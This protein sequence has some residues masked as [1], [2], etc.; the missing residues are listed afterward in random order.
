MRLTKLLL[1]GALALVSSHAAA[2]IVDGVRQKPTY[3]TMGFVTDTEV[4]LYNVG[5][6]QFFTQGNSWGTQA[7]VGEEGRLIKF[8]TNSASDYTM[9]CYCW[10]DENQQGGYMAADWRY[11]FYDSETQMFV[12]RN[13]QAN[14]FYTVVQNVDGTIRIS[15]SSND[16]DY[17]LYSGTMFMGVPKTKNEGVKITPFL[18]PTEGYVDWAIVSKESYESLGEQLAIYIKAQELKG[19]IDKIK[20]INGNYGSLESVYLDESSS[21]SQIEAAIANAKPLYDQARHDYAVSL[22]NNASDK[23]NVDITIALANP[24]F[25]ESKELE[26]TTT[27]WTTEYTLGTHGT[28]NNLRTGGTSTNLCYESWQMGT[29][30]IYQEVANMPAGVYEIEVQGFY[31]YQNGSNGWNAYQAQQ[32]EYVKDS[33]VP[34]YV[35]LNSNQ[36]PFSNIYKE[37]VPVNTLYQ[38]SSYGSPYTDPNNQYWYPNEMYNSAIAFQAGMYKRSAYGLVANDGETLRLGVKGS[39]DQSNASW[40]IWDNFKL[41]Y[42]GFQPDVVQP[43]LE[44]AMAD[45]NQYANLLMGKTE[46]ANLSNALSAAQT[47]IDNQDGEAMFQALNALYNVKESVIAS[48]DLFLAQ[49]VDTDLNNLRQAIT[50]YAEQKLS[51]A[52]RTAATT[53]ED[54][55]AGNK[56]Y[57]GSEISQLKEDVSNAINA[58]SNSAYQYSQL[59]TAITALEAAAQ[60]KAN[61]ALLNEA[62]ELITSAQEGYN[63][64]SFADSE[65]SAQVEAINA[66]VSAINTSASLY[67][68]LN[69]A[70]NNLQTSYD[71]ASAATAHVSQTT[72]LKAQLRLND[73]KTKY[74]N[75]TIADSNIETLIAT[76][77]SLGE[78]L[79][80]SKQLYE[81]F[82]TSIAALK[83]E[84]DK[85]AKVAAAVRTAAEGTYNAAVTAYNEGAIDDENIESENIKLNAAVASLSTSATRYQEL[86]AAIP[87]LQAA[88]E[89]KAMKSLI[90]DAQTLLTE[91][92]TGYNDAT[93]ADADIADIMANMTTIETSID[94]SAAQYELLVP[95]IAK[96]Q[97]AILEVSGE[98]AHV[99][100]TTR[101]KANLRLTQTQNQYN[102]GTI[103]DEQIPSR[104]T[105]IDDLCDELTHSVHL[106]NQFNENIAAL[107]TELDKNEKASAETR[108]AAETAYN[109]ALTAYNE[110]SIDDDNIEAEGLKL[111]AAIT[112][113]QNSVALYSQF[114]TAI[115]GLN[116]E[117]EKNNKVAATVR[118][119]ADDDYAA[120]VAAYGAGT[121]A[122][123]NVAAE[124]NKLNGDV[125]SLQSS[126]AAYAQLATAIA[127]LNTEL[128]KNAKVYAPV[129][130]AAETD[131]ATAND[132]YDQA[133]IADADIP[134]EVATLNA[135]VT[136]LQSSATAYEGLNTAITGFADAVAAADGKVADG[137]LTSANTLLSAT[138]TAYDEGS[139]ED[140]AIEGKKTEL[141]N[142]TG[143]LNAADGLEAKAQSR[144]SELGDLDTALAEVSDLLEQA[145][146]DM[147]TCYI[148]IDK[149]NEI[150]PILNDY[151]TSLSQ[152]NSDRD[153]MNDRLTT[154]KQTQT[155]AINDIGTAYGPALTGANNDLTAMG[156]EIADALSDL[157]DM[158]QYLTVEPAAAIAESSNII[159]LTAE[160]GTFCSGLDLDFTGA[161]VKAYI[162]SAY[163]P[164]EGK[165]I[166]TR[167]YDVPAGTGLVVRGVEGGHYEIPAGN[168][169]SVLS[170][171]LVGTTRSK[172]LP[173]EE[174]GK[175]NCILADGT[176]GLGFYPTSG[177]ILPAGKAYLPLPTSALNKTNGVK[178]VKLVFDDATGIDDVKFA[179]QEDIWYTVGGQM[180]QQK[181]SVPGI[182]VRN[183]KKV[184][185]K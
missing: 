43:V 105:L 24:D 47:A 83:T 154:D 79:L 158:K 71:E 115:A 129:R 137:L 86:N 152:L 127:A 53:L 78:E 133:T 29:F 125:T 171:M 132:A 107:K 76:L 58:F 1:C 28:D 142:A 48:K 70:I 159:D 25:E 168:G 155:T 120:A 114:N 94:E 174:D 164:E 10:R 68:Q 138:Q 163:I 147:E 178:G 172:D 74:Q 157:N 134:A 181:P 119:A 26:R 126:A 67:T 75:G 110:G 19:W 156:Q 104:V 96:L 52:T 13:N 7:S 100:N 49:G 124:V 162:V 91:V 8:V 12:D 30:D 54:N 31:R 22:I 112:N 60:K 117:L 11:V 2:T 118:T 77:N 111:Q 61:Q 121:I 39:T 87:A 140:A 106:Y 148:A 113:L 176:F 103:A 122:D 64:G 136:S 128:N 80:S 55:I 46:Y 141:F 57:E 177:G 20:A 166:L 95:A 92:Q 62:G 15:S 160:Y 173:V 182:Y 44:T 14:Y 33:G 102:E 98:T 81:Q 167:V 84:L 9:Q 6:A 18:L 180:L 4:Y 37:P 109:T 131:Y 34:V 36:T 149:R 150:Q 135:H 99:S 101:T 65:V 145:Q 143:N 151:V 85:N 161:D 56:K 66:K 5:A 21:M 93:I 184:V 169:S 72:L 69:T 27:G 153:G 175:T 165:V 123:A 42:R 130:S 144:T 41:R 35:Y 3:E 23:S 88:V 89:K 179:G 32:V 63:A 97:A 183:G 90:D 82:N 116:T 170:N 139:I 59:N 45:L 40:C 108:T 146:N 51:A 38:T 16:P 50:D 73:T 185:I 17:D